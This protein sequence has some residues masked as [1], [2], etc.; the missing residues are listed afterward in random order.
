MGIA[1]A[2][3]NN[4]FE[5]QQLRNGN[6]GCV[7]THLNQTDAVDEAKGLVEQYQNVEARVVREAFDSNSERY[8]TKT[9]FRSQPPL[10][11]RKLQEKHQKADYSRRAAHAKTQR[12]KKTRQRAEREAQRRAARRNLILYARIVLLL[13]LIG[14]GGL[15]ALYALKQ[16]R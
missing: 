14:G 9:I 12:H 16:L 4:V 13:A 1:T 3:S 7:S 10:D 15:A 8:V 5:V 6:W 2:S 11:Q